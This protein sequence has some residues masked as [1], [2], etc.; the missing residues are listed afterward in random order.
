LVKK[1][2][3]LGS[4]LK[5]NICRYIEEYLEFYTNSF[6][7]ECCDHS[8]HMKKGD[9]DSDLKFMI[10]DEGLEEDEREEDE[11]NKKPTKER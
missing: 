11:D 1:S 7:E 10:I 5:K 4:N 8:L 3:A 2:K 6:L 9:R